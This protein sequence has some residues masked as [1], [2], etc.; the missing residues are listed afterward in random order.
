MSEKP[1]QPDAPTL[2]AYRIHPYPVQMAMAE[3][4]VRH[5]LGWDEVPMKDLLRQYGAVLEEDLKQKQDR[6]KGTE[7]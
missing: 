5:Q 4:L 7:E 2:I 6:G 3:T 1:D